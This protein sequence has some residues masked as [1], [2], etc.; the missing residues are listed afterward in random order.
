MTPHTYVTLAAGQ[1]L[2]DAA[3][4]FRALQPGA[5]GG[6]VLA[7][8]AGTYGSYAA[9]YVS[10]GVR[11]E[12][13]RTTIAL[14]D[15]YEDDAYLTDSLLSAKRNDLELNVGRRLTPQIGVQLLGS[16]LHSSYYNQSFVSD[17]HL[18]GA[19]LVIQPARKV[20]V[21][22]LYDHLWRTV[23]GP[24]GTPFEENRVFLT[25]TYRP[26]GAGE[27]VNPTGLPPPPPMPVPGRLL[28]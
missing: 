10:G 20:E 24:V 16:T 26:I 23:S 15:R 5:A 25:L 9:R 4:G 19:S 3:E 11:F 22:L 17:D 21:R 27:A 8:V 7:P 28:P 14:T 6:I 1:Q 2:T 18:A 12:R 13:E